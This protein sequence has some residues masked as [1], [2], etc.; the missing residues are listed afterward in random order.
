VSYVEAMNNVQQLIT[1]KLLIT[2]WE[3]S[4]LL[5]K[6]LAARILS[7]LLWIDRHFDNGMK[8]RVFL[9]QSKKKCMIHRR[10]QYFGLIAVAGLG[11]ASSSQ[12]P[13]HRPKYFLF[14]PYNIKNYFR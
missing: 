13:A 10:K 8:I 14:R 4:G 1:V 11:F 12:F 6:V 2:P 5:R 9:L 3:H 7:K